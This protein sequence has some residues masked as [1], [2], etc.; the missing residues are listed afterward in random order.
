MDDGG[1]WLS[2]ISFRYRRAERV[3]IDQ[4][5][6]QPTAGAIALLGPNGAGKTTLFRILSTTLSPSSGSFGYAGL[7]SGNRRSIESMRRAIG[8][9]PQDFNPLSSYTCR[10]LLAYTAWLRQMRPDDTEQAISRALSSVD[11]HYC[12]DHKIRTLSGGT[13]RRLGLAQ[14][15][16][17]DPRLVL[18]DEPTVG[19]DPE[20]RSSFLQ[21]L[22]IVAKSSTV[23]L[24]THLVED[25]A[26][27]ASQVVILNAGQLVFS[28]SLVALCQTDVRG[29][30]TGAA[31]QEAYLRVLRTAAEQ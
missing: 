12:A 3:A 30:I 5:T 16:V 2:N 13:R 18:L 31:V 27:F 17:S 19:L 7:A 22:E 28:G 6:L 15:L 26:M 29:D 4:I 10:E 20:Q 1:L 24:A 21:K 25:V 8:F 23:L 11:L 9:L 14:A